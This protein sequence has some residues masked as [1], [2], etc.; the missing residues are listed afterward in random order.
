MT[1]AIAVCQQ[2]QNAF[3]YVAIAVFLTHGT[4][5]YYTARGTGK[6]LIFR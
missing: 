5:H 3:P 2:P 6:G 4:R 1:V